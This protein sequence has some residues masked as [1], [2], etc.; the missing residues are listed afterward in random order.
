MLSTSHQ[1]HASRAGWCNCFALLIL[2]P[3]ITPGEWPNAVAPS[4]T[5]ATSLQTVRLRYPVQRPILNRLR[6]MGGRDRSVTFQI[7]N[8]PR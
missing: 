4:G 6:D 3:F 2:L 1:T 5:E 8:S 7:R